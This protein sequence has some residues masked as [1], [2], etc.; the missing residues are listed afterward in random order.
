[1]NSGKKVLLAMAI[2]AITSGS[3]LADLDGGGGKITFTGLVISAPCSI[4]AE[5]IDKKVDLGDVTDTYINANTHSEA[6]D[7]SI[8]LENCAL[9]SSDN[10]AG[11]P[12][13]KAKVTFTSSNVV[14]GNPN[15]LSN[16]FAGGAT[17]VGV[18]LMDGD[19][20]NIVLG[21]A[22]EIPLDPD[23]VTQRL[24]FLAWMEKSNSAAATA[25]G[26]TSVVNYTLAYN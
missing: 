11:T 6:K 22:K 26:V 14:S 12:V 19:G 13:S 18:R 10:G 20:A 9:S 25:G 21:T 5:D 8:T 3:A 16:T 23:S 1:M 15:L 17:N 24:P 4:K 2:A 7:S